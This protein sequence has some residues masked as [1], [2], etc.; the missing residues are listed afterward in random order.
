MPEEAEEKRQG[1]I[2]TAILRV[3]TVDSEESKNKKRGIKKQ[4]EGAVS[5]ERVRKQAV[6]KVEWQ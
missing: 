2:R 1:L 5:K 3:K 6:N 4:S